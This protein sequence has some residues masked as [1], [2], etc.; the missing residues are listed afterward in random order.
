MTDHELEIMLQSYTQS[1]ADRHEEVGGYLLKTLPQKLPCKI[2]LFRRAPTAAAVPVTLYA[3]FVQTP[4]ATAMAAAVQATVT[5][6]IQLLFPPQTIEATLEGIS[7]EIPHAAYGR[8]PEAAEPGFAIYVDDERYQVIE[9]NGSTFIRP[10]PVV[11]TRKEIAAYNQALLEELS[12]TE[13]EA[14][15]DCL[16]ETLSI[17]R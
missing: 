9:E 13:A 2:Q 14:A 7:E 17:V 12:P 8:V 4:P 5:E 10:V 6:L 3:L 1:A 15:I 11:P 16:L